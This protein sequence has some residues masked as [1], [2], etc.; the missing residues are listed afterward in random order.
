MESMPRD[1]SYVVTMLI[2]AGSAMAVGCEPCLNQAIPN[3]IEAG[4]SGADIRRAVEIGHAVREIAA[5]N[6][7]Q[8]PG[9]KRAHDFQDVVFQR[10]VGFRIGSVVGL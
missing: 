10:L 9:V 1:E 4:V 2:A 7:Y 3:L 5:D 6:T 8:A